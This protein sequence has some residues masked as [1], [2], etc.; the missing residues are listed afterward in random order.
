MLCYL[1]MVTHSSVRVITNS[2]ENSPSFEANRSSA[3]EEIAHIL[4]KPKAHYR[5][6]KSPP[7]V[8]ILNQISP[9]PIIKLIC[10]ISILI[11]F[12]LVRLGLSSGLS[13][14]LTQT[15]YSFLLSAI[16]ATFK[17]LFCYNE[18]RFV[19]ILIKFFFFTMF[20]TVKCRSWILIFDAFTVKKYM[21]FATCLSDCQHVTTREHL[22][23]FSWNSVNGKIYWHLSNLPKFDQNRK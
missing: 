15:L 20:E 22:D 21:L 18:F 9:A 17:W 13:G 2:M 16:C 11:L 12:S 3:S 7:P 8:P 19:L 10:W 4:W 6:H 23:E 14:F 1:C 5:I